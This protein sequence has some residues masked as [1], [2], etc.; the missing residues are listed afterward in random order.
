[1]SDE[2]LGLTLK[3][4][5]ENLFRLRIQSQTER[6]D[7]PSELRQQ[8]PADRP[9][10]DDSNRAEPRRRA[11]SQPQ[12]AATSA[13]REQEPS[14]AQDDVVIGV[15]TSDKMTKTRRVEIAAWSGT[16]ST[17]SSCAAGRCATCTTRTTSRTMG[18]TVE[19]IESPPRVEAEAL[20]AGAGRVA[21]ASRSTSP[22]CGRPP[23]C[24]KPARGRR[25]SFSRPVAA[26]SIAE[27]ATRRTVATV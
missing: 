20:G 23:S 18:D 10:Q 15:V 22:R 25:E 16:R 27:S 12:T 9:H 14:H 3:E 5:A 6:L 13:A 26:S 2:Q 1:M 17:A 24:R 4:A 8:P 19:I 7:A 21:R 11:A